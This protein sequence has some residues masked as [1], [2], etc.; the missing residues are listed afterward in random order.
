MTFTR[1]EYLEV[2]RHDCGGRHTPA[3]GTILR[4]RGA[5]RVR[6][7]RPRTAHRHAS[8]RISSAVHRGADRGEAGRADRHGVVGR[9]HARR[10][11]ARRSG[12][13]ILSV[14]QPAVTFATPDVARRVARESNEWVAKLVADNPGASDRSRRCRCRMS[15]VRCAEIE[16]A[17]DTLK[18]DGVCLL[19]SYGD[20]WLGHASFAPVLDELNRRRAVVY[21]HPATADCCRNLLPGIP[22]HRHRVRHRHQPHDHRHR[23]QRDRGSLPR[24]AV[25]LFARRRNAAVPHRAA[26]R[27]CRCRMRRCRSASRAVC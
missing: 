18:A 22:G 11:G 26:G 16:Y 14:T 19:T 27:A 1:R 8:S 13:S 24:C 25:H 7:S 20:R 3:A 9:A 21:T 23:V 17:L 6:R 5:Y 10:H 2:C 12:A 15:T 4:A